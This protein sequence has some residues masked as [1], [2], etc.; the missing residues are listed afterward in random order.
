MSKLINRLVKEKIATPPK[1]LPDNVMYLCQM[2]SVA[3]G[4]A[5]EYSDKDIYGFCVPPKEMLYKPLN[6]FIPGFDTNKEF[7]Q[8]QEHHLK[9]SDGNEYDFSVYNITKF[10]A[11]VMQNNP[12]MIDSLF[13]SRDCILHSTAISEKVRENRRMFLHKGAY[14]KFKGYAFSTMHKLNTKYEYILKPVEDFEKKH[15]L[16]EK[17]SLGDIIEEIETRQL[18]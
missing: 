14:H 4:V 16:N 2:G 13:V 1:W 11:L 5:T 10:F 17:Y 18:A 3:Y 15:D 9:S 8:W 6:Q 7:Q 12:N